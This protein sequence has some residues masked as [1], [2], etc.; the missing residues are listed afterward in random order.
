LFVF[1]T[2]KAAGG[3]KEKKKKKK[4]VLVANESSDRS[5]RSGDSQ[6]LV[7]EED[8]FLFTP[9]YTCRR[10]RDCDAVYSSTLE[11]FCNHVY[12]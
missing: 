1:W 10:R 8:A 6:A 5:C 7:F 4:T 2:I 11:R 9:A 12:I 3:E